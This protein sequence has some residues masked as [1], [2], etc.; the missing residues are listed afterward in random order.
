MYIIFLYLYCNVD[1]LSVVPIEVIVAFNLKVNLFHVCLMLV[2]L[3]FNIAMLTFLLVSK[4]LSCDF[5][6]VM[7]K[8]LILCLQ[9]ALI[10]YYLYEIL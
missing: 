10:C 3:L 2:M 7:L 4:E 8:S 9:I 1:G 6:K 5:F